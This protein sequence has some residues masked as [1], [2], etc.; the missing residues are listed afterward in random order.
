MFSACANRKCLSWE[1]MDVYSWLCC[2]LL[3]T[4]QHENY[5]INDIA[6]AVGEAAREPTHY[7]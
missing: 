3:M 1:M 6:G 4:F 7:T 5:I 2:R